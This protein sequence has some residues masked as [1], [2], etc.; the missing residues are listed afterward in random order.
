[1]VRA[2]GGTAA[3]AATEPG[4]DAAGCANVA[5]PGSGSNIAG[6]GASD[7]AAAAGSW[8]IGSMSVMLAVLSGVTQAVLPVHNTSGVE[9]AANL[10]LQSLLTS[11]TRSARPPGPV[12]DTLLARERVRPGRDGSGDGGEAVAG[13]AGRAA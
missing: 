2:D 10:A 3:C 7:A 9:R 8:M 1:M 6:G 13:A 4:D 5:P 12:P 11:L